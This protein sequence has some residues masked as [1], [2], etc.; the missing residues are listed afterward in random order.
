MSV[1][2][3][4]KKN[5]RELVWWQVVIVIGL[6]FVSGSAGL[7]IGVTQ[8]GSSNSAGVQQ[9]LSATLTPYSN[10]L[11]QLL[12]KMADV[13]HSKSLK[14]GSAQLDSIASA[15]RF[16]GSASLMFDQYSR[17]C[18]NQTSTANFIKAA[19]SINNPN[20]TISYTT[21]C[22]TYYPALIRDY[23]SQLSSNTIT[24]VSSDFTDLA[25]NLV[26]LDNTI[27]MDP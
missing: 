18:V 3:G 8:A 22:R 16:A 11:Q 25:F 4:I 9:S 15:F 14:V 20:F 7:I 2:E 1:S 19:M 26:K 23:S 21:A 13:S 5:L 17:L 6:C 24:S 27:T 12:D 10:F